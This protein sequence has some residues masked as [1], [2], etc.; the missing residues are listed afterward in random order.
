MPLS[1][2][3]LAEIFERSQGPKRGIEESQ[4]VRGKNVIQEEIAIAM[5][6]LLA[7]FHNQSTESFDVFSTDDLLRPDR[8]FARS[9]LG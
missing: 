1:L 8:Q 2:P 9:S 6:I 4:E 7:K 3:R 5:S